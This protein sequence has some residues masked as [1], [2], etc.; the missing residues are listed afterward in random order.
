MPTLRDYFVSE[1]KAYFG[2]LTEQFNRLDSARGEPDELLR[3]ARA[4]RGSAHLARETRVYRAGLG[5]E[6]AARALA[7]GALKWNPDVSGRARRAV[8][9]LQTLA[10][11]EAE[12]AAEARVKRVLDR[13]R[14][15]G[16]QLPP[17]AEPG[18]TRAQ[19][20]DRG[21]ASR[22]FREF[23]AHEVAGIASEIENAFAQLAE[24]PHNREPLKAILRRQRALLGAARLDEITVVA[25]TLRA[26]EDLVRIIVK[27]D[28]PVRDEWLAVFRA[29]REVLA[30]AVG[31]LRGGT[32]PTAS[33]ALNSLRTL[34]S[35]LADRHDAGET[36]RGAGP[37]GP[38]PAPASPE[39]AQ[40]FSR[41]AAPAAN[42]PAGD[43]AVPI[44]RLT[45]QGER[46]L[47]RALELR[48]DLENFAGDNTDVREVVD[49]VF[50]L[51]RLGLG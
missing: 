15:I 42:G 5:L 41:A 22:Q 29:A 39:P 24:D 3:L 4:L 40:P 43:D 51:I 9:D 28:V 18:G 46:A 17:D 11:G 1:S 2:Q 30:S 16:I 49:E 8:E 38:T 13:W 23:A 50:D 47:R 25:E 36:S 10:A 48:A 7:A 31:P 6:A 27:I 44:E 37:P 33:P 34:R 35:E 14:E 26:I 32:D 19:T 12:A 20:V 45:Y 21:L